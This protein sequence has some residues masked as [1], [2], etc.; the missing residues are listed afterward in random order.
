MGE[1]GREKR[2]RKRE[3]KN[4]RKSKGGEDGSQVHLGSL[5]ADALFTIFMLMFS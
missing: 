3:S 2:Q 1:E 4:K 5:K